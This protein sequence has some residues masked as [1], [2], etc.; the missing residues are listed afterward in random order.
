[1]NGTHDTIDGLL[2][3][4]RGYAAGM[5]DSYH[6][7]MSWHDFRRMLN[8]FDAAH[9]RER[10][11]CAKLREALENVA[12]QLTDATEDE[13]FGEDVMYLV[14]CMRTMS[15]KCRAALAAPPRNY[16]SF[17][18]GD[19]MKDAE[20]AYGAWQRYCDDPMIPP[21]CKVESSFKNWLFALATEKEGGNGGR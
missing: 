11:D 18:S 8:R 20:D 10:G 17:N 2:A 5:P 6:V 7:T 3:E 16:D 15:Q 9:R 14:G 13:N 1:M 4:F 21:S 19:P 12:K